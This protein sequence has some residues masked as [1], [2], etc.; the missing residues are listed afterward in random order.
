MEIEIVLH[1]YGGLCEEK[2][3]SIIWRRLFL[4]S[5]T[6][7]FRSLDEQI[8]LL[9]AR[10]LIITDEEYAKSFLLTQ[11]YYNIINGYGKFFPHNGDIYSNRTTFHEIAQ[12]YNFER[13]IKQAF[14]QATIDIETHLKS[15]FA[16]RFS[17]QHPNAKYPYLDIK[18]YDSNKTL[19]VIGTISRLSSKI[20]QY[21]KNKNHSISHYVNSYDNVPIWVLANYLDFGELK[22]MLLNSMPVIQNYVASD[23]MLFI[24]D[25]TLSASIFPPEIMLSFVASINDIRNICAH[26]NRLIG[27]KCHH[28]V[29]HWKPLHSKFDI[30]KNVSRNTPYDVYLV[31]QCFLSFNEFATL[32]NKLRKRFLNLANQLHSISINL[33]LKDFGFPDDWHKNTRS[34]K[35]K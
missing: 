34:V 3:F 25:N 4:L 28:D 23:M 27:F 9:S 30:E 10:Q 2:A 17:E 1:L 18:C 12:L 14:L 8:K 32:H 21:K 29:K 13:E 35:H 7:D 5:K 26:N 22:Y 15:S 11:N 19:N 20:N 6:K 33:I 31:S 16:Y 24:E